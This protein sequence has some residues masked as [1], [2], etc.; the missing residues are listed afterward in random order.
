[1]E[2]SR[3]QGRKFSLCLRSCT[4][5]KLWSM[6]LAVLLAP[7]ALAQI[8][9][10]GD[11]QAAAR[12]LFRQGDF[13]GAA[14]AFQKMI[15]RQP[16][17]DA[18]V[19]LV[20]SFLKLDDIQAAEENSRRALEQFPQSPLMHAT[21]GDVY[22]RRGL[23]AEAQGEYET[24]LKMD[25][26]CARA[27]LGRG[28][29]YS[30]ASRR[31][32]SR[33][34]LS[35]AR[36]LDPNDGDTWYSWAAGLSYPENVTELEKHMTEFRSDAER[37]RHEHEYVDFLKAL[38]GRKVWIPAREINHSEINLEQIVIVPGHVRGVGMKV[39]LNDLATVSL[40]LDTGASGILIGLKLAEKIKARKLSDYSLEGVGDSGPAKGYFAWVDK[41]TIGDFEFHDCVVHVSSKNNVTAEDGLIGADV[42]D[43]YLVT[44]DFPAAKLRL[45]PLPEPTIKEADEPFAPQTGSFTQVFSFGHL[46]LMPTQVGD[47]AGGLFALDTGAVTNSISLGLARQVSKVRDSNVPVK[48]IS[49]SVKNVFTTD[50]AVLQF[51]RF[52][53]PHEDITTFDVHSLSK[54]LGTEVSG[55]IG[56]TTLKKMKLIIN[57]RDGLVDFDYKP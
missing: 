27:W 4:V 32:Q 54:D 56:F 52:R 13:A 9:A 17:A 2:F 34:A 46:L 10:P 49:G 14:A 39:R 50:Q 41:I 11:A 38:A 30:A 15:D 29:I 16:S 26:K 35:R 42:F 22:F 1:M 47:T 3:P 28:Q 5:A 31:K 44:V 18:H 43:K 7:L 37:E 51:S 12:L 48:G 57:Y 6:L 20:Q 45:N 40:L 53:Q 55:M 25:P 19:G 21:R 23:M 33:A 24:A 8:P 36:E